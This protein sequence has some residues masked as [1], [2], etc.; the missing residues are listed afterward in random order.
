[1]LAARK[2]SGGC[3]CVVMLL[4]TCGGNFALWL[5]MVVLV[6]C[7]LYVYLDF[8]RKQR[9]W[10]SV[11][12]TASLLKVC[13]PAVF[14]FLFQNNWPTIPPLPP[15]HV[16]LTDSRRSC[17]HKSCPPPLPPPPPTAGGR[18]QRSPPSIHEVPVALAAVSVAAWKAS[19]D[20]WSSLTTF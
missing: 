20:L 16:S 13:M 8:K 6:L 10:M 11:I 17:L 15:R 4:L 3:M 12:F 7:M 9:S 14:L 2:L 1:M 19:Q 18:A 5:C